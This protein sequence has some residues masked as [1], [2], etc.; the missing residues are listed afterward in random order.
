MIL[1]GKIWEIPGFFRRPGG[2]CEPYSLIVKSLQPAQ[3]AFPG[4]P[5]CLY[6]RPEKRSDGLL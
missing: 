5:L 6:V 1:S 4:V 3:T 2:F